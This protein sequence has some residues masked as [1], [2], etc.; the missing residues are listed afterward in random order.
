[1]GLY[2]WGKPVT[3]LQLFIITTH[4]ASD[5]S[6]ILELKRLI[7]ENTKWLAYGHPANKGHTAKLGQS[8]PTMKFHSF[9]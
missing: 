8:L 4:R 9:P 1:M 6:S 5:S 7:F 2:I 3:H